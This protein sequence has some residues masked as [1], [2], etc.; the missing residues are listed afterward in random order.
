MNRLIV[1]I[2]LLLARAAIVRLLAVLLGVLLL[3]LAFAWPR[4]AGAEPL[5]QS[6]QVQCLRQAT[7]PP[8]PAGGAVIAGQL[9]P[10]TSEPN[11]V[12]IPAGATWQTGDCGTGASAIMAHPI[13]IAVAGPPQ[14]AALVFEDDQHGLFSPWGAVNVDANAPRA[15][16]FPRPPRVHAN[17]GTR[18]T[19]RRVVLL[20]DLRLVPE[21]LAQGLQRH[22]AHAPRRR[23]API[24]PSGAI[25]VTPR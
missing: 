10:N 19:A 1:L 24:T 18:T 4:P 16:A 11:V 21:L 25:S 6:A 7:P 9:D 5:L 3:A 23:R 2:P 17:E 12:V 15:G 20:G 22:P 14:P 8:P 13:S